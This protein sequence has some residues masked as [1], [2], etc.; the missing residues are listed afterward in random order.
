M[1]ITPLRLVGSGTNVAD[2]AIPSGA[3]LA[4]KIVVTEPRVNPSEKLAPLVTAFAVKDGAAGVAA[5]SVPYQ[6]PRPATAR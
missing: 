1:T 3:R 2:A 6:M 4:P 5:G